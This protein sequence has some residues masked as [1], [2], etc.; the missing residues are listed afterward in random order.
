MV[1]MNDRPVLSTEELQSGSTIRIGETTLRFVAF[2][3]NGFSW[4][5]EGAPAH[6]TAS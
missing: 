5:E 1:R 3:D 4:N 6:A 2:C